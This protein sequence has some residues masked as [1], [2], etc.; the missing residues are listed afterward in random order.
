VRWQD[1]DL[2]CYLSGMQQCHVLLTRISV[3]P[4][5][6]WDYNDE[7]ITEFLGGLSGFDLESEPSQQLEHGR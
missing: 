2:D 7:L 4:S 3:S 6:K 1:W 5:V